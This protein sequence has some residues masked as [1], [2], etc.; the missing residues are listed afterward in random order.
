MSFLP[1]AT[2]MVCAL[3]LADRLVG[4]THE[5][6][7]PPEIRNRPIVVQGAMSL[8][9]LTPQEIDLAVAAQ[10]Q[11]RQSLY[12]LNE[13][14]LLDLA[15]NLI[16]TQDLCQVCAP[17]GNEITQVLK[18]LPSKPQILWLTPKSLSDIEENLRQLGK[19]T[20]RSEQAQAV[21]A[22][23]QARLA[24]VT[25][26]TRNASRPRLFFM[27]WT[28]PIY[29]GGH[30]VPEMIEL[31]GGMDKLSR[32]GAD[33]VRVPWQDVLDWAP[34]VLVIAPCGFNLS[35]A[36]T[37]AALLFAQPGWDRI[38]AVQ[39]GRVYAV[40]ANAFFARPGPRLIEGVELLAHLLH[41]ERCEWTGSHSAFQ[42]ICR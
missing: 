42:K 30:W 6:D 25:A 12:R 19:A 7:F 37:Q 17:S 3:G 14:L 1:A 18:A 27:E 40:D 15:P 39:Q 28:D 26:L 34:E 35:E 9:G 22:A 33:S 16:V 10:M 20:G 4:I 38:P 31:A 2:E 29:C 41:P 36:S 5:C 13:Q 8:S 24:K 21:I 32:P 23:G 11:N